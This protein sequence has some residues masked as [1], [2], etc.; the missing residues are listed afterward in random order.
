[1]YYWWFFLQPKDAVLSLNSSSIYGS[2][3]DVSKNKLVKIIKDKQWFTWGWSEIVNFMAVTTVV[4]IRGEGDVNAAW[5]WGNKFSGHIRQSLPKHSATTF[6]VPEINNKNK[7]ET[8]IA[9]KTN[10]EENCK[11]YA[12]NM[13]KASSKKK[14]KNEIRSKITY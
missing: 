12:S 14:G 13:Y 6:R 7:M 4:R 3:Y 10:A 11:D 1:M 2:D 8:K 9:K 5:S